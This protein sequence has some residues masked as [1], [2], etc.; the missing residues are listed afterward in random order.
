MY[1]LNSLWL[2]SSHFRISL[3][4]LVKRSPKCKTPCYA[5]TVPCRRREAADYCGSSKHSKFQTRIG[6]CGCDRR[7]SRN[8]SAGIRS[9]QSAERQ[10]PTRAKRVSKD[11][12]GRLLSRESVDHLKSQPDTR[13]SR[14][15]KNLSLAILMWNNLSRLSLW[16]S[17]ICLGTITLPSETLTL[18]GPRSNLLLR[19][20]GWKVRKSSCRVT[21]FG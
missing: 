8:Y 2:T 21:L 15:W 7:W 5:A 11:R 18:Y 10:T 9:Q 13:S 3:S 12:H 6:I 4:N 17:R 20:P 16:F 19:R 14:P 1:I